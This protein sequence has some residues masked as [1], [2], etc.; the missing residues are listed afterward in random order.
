MINDYL[1]RVV[2][3][4]LSTVPGIGEINILGGPQLAMRLWL[5]PKKMA[6]RGVSALE[7]HR[8]F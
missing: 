7:I 1:V 8:R 3:P 4:I 2:T 6:S 5:D